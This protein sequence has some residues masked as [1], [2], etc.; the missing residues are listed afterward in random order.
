[1]IQSSILHI[2]SS[3]GESIQS[4]PNTRDTMT[5]KTKVPSRLLWCFPSDDVNICYGSHGMIRRKWNKNREWFSSECYGHLN[6]SEWGQEMFQFLYPP[7]FVDIRNDRA[8]FV[9]LFDVLQCL[10][11]SL[12]L[13]ELRLFVR[14]FNRD[15][16]LNFVIVP[17][18][19]FENSPTLFEFR[20]DISTFI[21]NC[22]FKFLSTE[23]SS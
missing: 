17:Y 23:N 11:N 2:A 3:E 4:R 22:N 21:L 9:F 8:L 15:C 20:L 10:E 14:R 12:T 1:M 7:W 18:N 13:F 5:R 6:E 19:Y 16:H